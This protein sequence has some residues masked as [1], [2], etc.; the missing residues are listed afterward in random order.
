MLT[1]KQRREIEEE[2]IIIQSFDETVRGLAQEIL[3]ELV[4]DKHGNI[5]YYENRLN[6][7]YEER[8]RIHNGDFGYSSR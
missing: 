5:D 4:N 7:L 1:D 2:L 3:K 6:K 8:R